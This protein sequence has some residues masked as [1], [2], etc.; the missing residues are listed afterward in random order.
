MRTVLYIVIMIAVLFAPVERVDIAKMQPVEAVAVRKE[1]DRIQLIT[2]TQ[3]I[4]EGET[5]EQALENLRETAYAIVY[6]DTA[7]FLLVEESAWDHVHEL[8]PYLKKTIRIG[9]YEGGDIAQEARFLSVHRESQ[10]PMG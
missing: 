3:D 9:S 7:Q 10:R 2:D 1:N 4:G 8:L 5:V 6:L